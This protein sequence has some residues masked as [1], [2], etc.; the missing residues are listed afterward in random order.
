VIT[1]A[2]SLAF[3]AGNALLLKGGKESDSTSRVLYGLI[4]ES[5]TV[6]GVDPGV[7]WGLTEAPREMT[8]FLLKQNRMIDVLIP[9][10]GDKLIEH[11]TN[12]ST[13]PLIKNDRGLCHLYVHAKANLEM[14]LTILDNA[15]TQ[16]P[17]V[18]N[19]VETLLVDEATAPQFLP[20]V[21]QLLGSKNVDFY[22]CEKSL[23]ILGESDVVH[24]AG[25]QTYDTEYLDLK[26]SIK[27]VRDVDE[28]MSHI[29][30]HGSR[31]SESII[32]TDEVVASRFQSGVDAAAVY[33]NAST[34]FTD[35]GQMGLGAEIGI[36][37]QKLHVR[38]PVGLEALT[39]VRWIINGE[40]QVR[41]S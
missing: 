35:G 6:N 14:A 27:V 19:A 10:G 2:F 33:W 25:E 22:G 17:S 4:E 16:R 38:G 40:G 8:D 3:K 36:S 26:L 13:I 29:E 5:L 18:C 30:K 9:R 12:H 28:A 21:K 1:E 31:H 11:V 32:T 23:A 24:K 39:S 15:K 20:K 37:T 41:P 34:R 7:F